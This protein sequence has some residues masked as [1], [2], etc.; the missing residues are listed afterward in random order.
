MVQEDPKSAPRH[1]SFDITILE[2]D[3]RTLPPQLQRNLFQVGRRRRL[4]DRPSDGSGPGERDFPDPWVFGDGGADGGAVALD[5]V[6]GSLSKPKSK[7]KTSSQDRISICSIGGNF[8]AEGWM[9]MRR[10]AYGREPSLIDQITH[11]QRSQRRK[12]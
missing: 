12:L 9:W 7:K 5:D 8:W 6:D 2:H 3:I 1:R 10:G 4:H 11:V